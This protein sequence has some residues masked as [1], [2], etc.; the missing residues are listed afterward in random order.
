[1]HDMHSPQEKDM[2]SENNNKNTKIK[3]ALRYYLNT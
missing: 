2:F 3:D 1:M